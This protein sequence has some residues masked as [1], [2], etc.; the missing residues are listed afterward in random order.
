MKRIISKA[1]QTKA[2]V[3]SL[4][5]VPLLFS[6]GG[7]WLLTAFNEAPTAAF[8]ISSQA[9]QAP[10]AVNFS[11]VL[12]EDAD[13][14]IVKFE[15]DFGDG[16]SGSGENVSHTFTTA[17]TFTIVLRV[18]DDDGETATNSKKI[19]V[20]P[21]EPAGP[22]ASFTFSPKSGTSPMTVFFDA[23]ASTYA[24][25]VISGYEWSFGDGS[26]GFGRNPSHTYFSGESRNYTVTLTV[27][28]TDGKTGTATG[29]VTIS[30]AA[31]AGD[32]N[33][34][35]DPSARFD[36]DDSA[37]VAPHRVEL[38][39]SDSEA[40]TGRVITAYIWS[41]GDGST[42]N[43]LSPTVVNH[44][45]ITDEEDEVFSIT[46]IVTDDGNPAGSDS[47]TKTVRVE[48][49]Q[50]TAGFEVYSLLD[51]GADAVII[52]GGEWWTGLDEDDDDNDDDRVTFW[53]VNPAADNEVWIRTQ[54]IVDADWE[55]DPDPDDDGSLQPVPNG[56]NDE[57]GEFDDA[58]GNN[59]CFDPEGQTWDDPEDIVPD[60]QPDWFPNRAWGIQRLRISWGDGNADIVEFEDA[61]DTVASHIYDFSD[62]NVESWTITVTAIDYLGA[63]A[64]FSRVVTFTEATDPNP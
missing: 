28:G 33:D 30:G 50:P 29:T 57:P 25:G 39:P 43:T 7:C 26:T 1:R 41:Y 32:D 8:T 34:A 5:L 56:E 21:A 20:T 14:T 44:T 45:Y 63:E 23:A 54:Q 53:D 49:Y 4:L 52:G 3:V 48:N 27:R 47:I 59:M 42:Q 31:G 61:A 18:T 38:D 15:W 58:N 6:L 17:G 51:D 22:T 24:A 12:S 9:G 13:G 36:I 11:A 2:V 60:A 19:Y 16:S 62:G 40:D 35:G 46:L 55:I 10:F 37:G 64:S